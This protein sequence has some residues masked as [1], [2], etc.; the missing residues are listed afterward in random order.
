VAQTWFRE[1]AEPWNE[2]NGARGYGGITPGRTEDGRAGLRRQHRNAGRPRAA[3]EEDAE[4]KALRTPN[5]LFDAVAEVTGTDPATAGSH[6]GK[7]AAALARAD[8]PHTPDDVR[9]FARRF[10]DLCTWARDAT[11]RV[12][13]LGEVQKYKRPDLAPP[14]FPEGGAA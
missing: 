1:Q 11:R 4:A 3:D 7:V 12:P 8:P 2:R 6:I 10:W 13:E 9:A 14:A 5:P